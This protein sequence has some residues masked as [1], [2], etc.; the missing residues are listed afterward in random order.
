M[1]QLLLIVVLFLILLFVIIVALCVPRF[2]LVD[3]DV[4]EEGA[5]EHPGNGEASLPN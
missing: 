3:I 4:D 1:E 5:E 2:S